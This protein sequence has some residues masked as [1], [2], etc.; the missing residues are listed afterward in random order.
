MLDA[1]LGVVVFGLFI[2]AV[3][4]SLLFSQRGFLASGDRMRAVFLTEQLLE[5]V[6]SIRDSDFSLLAEG[7]FGAR[8]GAGNVWELWGTGAVTAD[9]YASR[10]TIAASGADTVFATAQTSW[11]HGLGRSGTVV[12][13][14]EITNWRIEQPVGDWSSV[15]Q[16]GEY[17]DGGVPVFNKVVVRGDYAYVTS[18]AGGAGLYVFDISDLGNPTRVASAFSLGAAGYGLLAVRDVLYV[19]TSDTSAELRSYDISSPET[20]AADDLIAQVNLAGDGRA[21]S[22]AYF[23][24]SLFVGAAEDGAADE[25]YSYAASGGVLTL[26]DSFDNAGGFL[27]IAIRQGYAYSGNTQDVAE[28]RVLDVF[29]PSDIV[30]A[31]GVGYNVTDVYDGNAI[32]AFGTG[33]M[34]GR[35]NGSSIEELVLFD[36]AD[37]DVPSPPPGPWYHEVGGDAADLGVEPGGSYVFLASNHADKELQVVDPRL[38]SAGLP[39]EVEYYDS[40]NGAG[41]GLFYDMIRDRLFL[42]TNDAL[43]ILRPAP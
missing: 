31:P 5:A 9:G 26:Q 30:D 28:L 2:A 7:T 8:I 6:R 12:L 1:L 41:N 24:G 32:L 42:A 40:A 17:I 4:S 25:F 13:T 21:R 18:G 34:L 14:A 39:A 19:T 10:V 20:L 23:D 35:V 16:E 11:N 29:D 36:I 33:V 38:L 15:S 37:S 22:L 27:D 43:E 3:G